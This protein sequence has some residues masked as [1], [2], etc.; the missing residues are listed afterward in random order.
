MC[1][2]T[3]RWSL[4]SR[5]WA[6]SVSFGAGDLFESGCGGLVNPVNTEGII[7]KGLAAEFK[8]RWPA[9]FV[10]YQQ[11]CRNG[12]LTVGTVMPFKTTNQG[13]EVWILNFPTKEKGRDPSKPEYVEKGLDLRRGGPLS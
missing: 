11:A 2:N 7:G 6:L 3:G 4:N 9:M 5:S 8:R 1:Q 12:M 10:M 13:R